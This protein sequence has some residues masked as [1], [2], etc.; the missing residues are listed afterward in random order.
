M[1]TGSSVHNQRVERL[2]RDMHKSVTILYYRLFYFMEHNLLLNPLNELHLWALHYVFLPRINKASLLTPGT[3]MELEQ[4]A[5]NHLN[6]CLLL[7]LYYFK[8][9]T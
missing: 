6:N 4:L 8:T 1:I 5:I 2:W 9:Q 7:V 3:I